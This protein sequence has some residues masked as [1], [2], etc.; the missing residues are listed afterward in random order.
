MSKAVQ[1]SACDSQS[2]SCEGDSA[3]DVSLLDMNEKDSSGENWASDPLNSKE[4]FLTGDDVPDFLDFDNYS[5]KARLMSASSSPLLPLPTSGDWVEYEFVDATSR[6]QG[7][8]IYAY[9]LGDKPTFQTK[10]VWSVEVEE[11]LQQM[12]PGEIKAFKCALGQ[13]PVRIHLKSHVKRHVLSGGHTLDVKSESQNMKQ[14]TLGSVVF[15]SIDDVSRRMTLDAPPT[16]DAVGEALLTLKVGELGLLTL[17]GAAQKQTISVLHVSTYEDVSPLS[18]GSLLKLTLDSPLGGFECPR[19]GHTIEATIDGAP[20]AWQWG[21]GEVDNHLEFAALS[22]GCGQSAEFTRF[23]EDGD[24]ISFLLRI[25]HIGAVTPDA[26]SEPSSLEERCCIIAKKLFL[27]GN[28]TLARWH[29]RYVCDRLS[30]VLSVTASE[31]NDPDDHKKQTAIAARA[32][33]NLAVV[34]GRL[35]RFGGAVDAAQKNMTLLPDQSKRAKDYLR[36]AIALESNNLLE[37]ARGTCSVV[38]RCPDVSPSD[39]ETVRKI[40]GCTAKKHKLQVE[41]ERSF[42]QR[43]FA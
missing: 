19:P 27:I 24:K 30:H 33:G 42:C 17:A 14:A 29:W 26:A 10:D 4:E 28:Y 23:T 20:A 18:D 5:E 21:L 25:C 9:R 31:I 7:S 40:F 22:V 12:R 32:Y 36:L 41:E 34:E 6:P 11:C 15:Y 39:R 8:G 35:G 3:P 2:V 43:M 38:L 1:L 37:E 13:S 16:A